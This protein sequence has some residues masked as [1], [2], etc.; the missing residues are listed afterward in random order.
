MRAHRLACAV[1]A[2]AACQ[3]SPAGVDATCPY[4]WHADRD[5]DGHGDPVAVASYDPSPPPGY[6]AG[7][8][9]CDD[10]S[11]LAYPGHAEV[12][13]GLDNDCDPLR[14]PE[15]ACPAWC[16]VVIR[17]DT[18]VR[19]L[20][21]AQ[22][23]AWKAAANL[24]A[25][26]DSALVH[27]SDADEDAWLTGQIAARFAAEPTWLGGSSE[28]HAGD[29]RWSDDG[30][31]FWQAGHAVP[32]AYAAAGGV[33]DP[34][35]GAC[36]T[37]TRTGAWRAAPCSASHPFVCERTPACL[38]PSGAL[39][40]RCNGVDD[41]C[42]GAVDDGH[43]VGAPCQ[44]GVGGCRRD[45]Q[46]TCDASGAGVACDAVAGAPLE[47]V[48]N[49]VDDDCDGEVDEGF[50][51]DD[52]CT[53]GIGACTRSGH[54]VC[55]PDGAGVTCDQLPGPPTTE[56]CGNGIDDDCDGQG[57]NGFPVGDACTT[58]V[59]ACA[60]SGLF[61]C[62]A[63]GDGVEC[64]GTPGLPTAEVCGDAID[65]DCDG[66][67]KPLDHEY[68]GDGIDQDC[69]GI[70]EV[71]PAN[72]SPATPQ[73]ISAGGTF[74]VDLSGSHDDDTAPHGTSTA[75]GGS[76][77]GGRDVFYQFTVAAKDTVYFD[78][79]GSNF[80]PVLRLYAGTCAARTTFLNCDYHSSFDCNTDDFSH[81]VQRVDPG[82]YC[83]VVDQLDYTE[84]DGSLVLRYQRSGRIGFPRPTSV[85]SST[86]TDTNAM[87]PTCATASTAPDRGY[88][89]MLC[90][91]QALRSATLTAAATAV[92]YLRAAGATADLACQRAS[93][94]GSATIA[95]PASLTPGLYWYV[96]DS[97]TTGCQNYTFN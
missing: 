15:S 78:T 66:F 91:G 58:G 82:T 53:Q 33:V 37:A 93:G 25:T 45:G 29:W 22:P 59:G 97:V 95:P 31:L 71:C 75:C 5:G 62:S 9:D 79:W 72:D 55:S 90:P 73:D 49:G 27:V 52:A 28:A 67:D 96:V 50:A 14:A 86:C 94:T 1:L 83:L 23:Y 89:T 38:D 68:C 43:G 4:A 65:Q 46:L 56:V 16:D 26:Q 18:G 30:S 61:A 10:T 74:T 6:V 7:A 69:S 48:C 84:W 54:T 20:M 88:Y 41:D 85:T 42:D 63:A 2:L 13:D 47:E 19:Y 40:E 77:G 60:R 64:H 44:V 32:G 17:P 81:V 24:C 34:G 80:T 8:D 76:G 12:C 87:T 51:L 39:P 92:L 11:A 36:V 35:A 21:C 3:G 70:D 57:D